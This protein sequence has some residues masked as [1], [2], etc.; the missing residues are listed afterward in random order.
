MASGRGLG[1]GARVRQAS[2]SPA[3]RLGDGGGDS[4]W[5]L[6]PEVWDI[7]THTPGC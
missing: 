4:A 3:L 2:H 6:V 1:R 5:G 7:H